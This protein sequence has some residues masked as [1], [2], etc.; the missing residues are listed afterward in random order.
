MT[1]S[2]LG[3]EAAATSSSES[4]NGYGR[5]LRLFVNPENMGA[6]LHDNFEKG[7]LESGKLFC[8]AYSC[9]L[10]LNNGCRLDT[11]SSRGRSRR[12][13]IWRGL[14]HCQ[15]VFGGE[16]EPCVRVGRN[17][18]ATRCLG[19]KQETGMVTALFTLDFVRFRVSVGEGANTELS[20]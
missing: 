10:P 6:A 5:E 17:K 2:P 15:R 20:D 12:F 9:I 19:V 11:C 14:A 1:T 18:L 13:S 16:L 7:H 8:N 4:S 3:A